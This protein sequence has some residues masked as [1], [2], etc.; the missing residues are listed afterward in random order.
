MPERPLWVETE[1]RGKS[2]IRHPELVSGSI[3]EALAPFI[4]MDA[5]TSSA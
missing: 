3:P 5:E 2:S 1:R 4:K